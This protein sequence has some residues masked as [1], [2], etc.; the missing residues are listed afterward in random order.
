MPPGFAGFKIRLSTKDTPGQ[1]QNLTDYKLASKNAS[2]TIP[3]TT[4]LAPLP[5][6]L[7]PP[8]PPAATA[9]TVDL[10]LLYTPSGSPVSLIPG[11]NQPSFIY[12]PVKDQ[13]KPRVAPRVINYAIAGGPP[14][15]TLSPVAPV[16]KQDL[17]K[18]Y[19]GLEKSVTDGKATFSLLQSAISK[20]ATLP[21]SDAL[22]NG[23]KVST[24]GLSAV[25]LPSVEY[26]AF[27]VE[28]QTS[29]GTSATIVCAKDKVT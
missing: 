20:K 29:G 27:T 4:T 5:P 18:A 3:I 25:Q 7:A 19:P 15:I 17:Y 28:Y 21:I 10:G 26:D 14:D 8:A 9:Y 23:W 11:T 1:W 13:E 6:A 2:V 16:T 12:F 22:G 24:T